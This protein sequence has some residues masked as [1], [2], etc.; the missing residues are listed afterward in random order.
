MKLKYIKQV[1]YRIIHEQSKKCGGTINT[2][3]RIHKLMDSSKAVSLIID[4][5][6]C[7]IIHLKFQLIETVFKVNVDDLKKLIEKYNL[8]E[9]ALKARML[10]SFNFSQNSQHCTFKTLITQHYGNYFKSM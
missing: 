8:A 1:T 2:Y 10:D 7:S 6:P 4:I 5:A 3:L 9:D